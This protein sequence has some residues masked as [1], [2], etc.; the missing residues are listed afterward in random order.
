VT[1][2]VAGVRLDDDWP[3][4]PAALSAVSLPALDSLQ[5]SRPWYLRGPAAWHPRS[6]RPAAAAPIGAPTV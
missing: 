5:L 1:R 4:S 3:V 2:E 6:G